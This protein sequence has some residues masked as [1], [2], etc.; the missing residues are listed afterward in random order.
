MTKKMI[1]RVTMLS[2]AIVALTLIAAGAGVFWQGGG[3]AYK[4][5]TL[6]G[7]TVMINGHGLYRYD[8]V[9][10]A[11]QAVAQDIVT[12]L[13]GIPFLL[14][15]LYYLRGDSLRG[16]LL[17][18]GITGYFLYTYM[19]YAVGANYNNMF[20]IY[21][22]VFSLSLSTLSMILSSIDLSTL[23]TH[24]S[25]KTPERSIAVYL[26][27]ISFLLFMAWMGRIV[28]AMIAGTAPAGLESNTT[29]FIQFMDLAIVI[30]LSVVAGILLIR[31]QPLGYLLSS[32][33]IIKTSTLAFSV[34]AMGLNMLLSGAS[35]SPAELIM[36]PA[37][38]VSG[39]V[40][41]V[42]MLRSITEPAK[43]TEPAEDSK[44]N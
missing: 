15:S 22:A 36:F 3:S 10:M 18:C 37:I 35:V 29:L 42:L 9:S 31:K 26:L 34:S 8:T 43:Q 30:P 12:L 40:L 41:M 23:K 17:F 6:R 16:K 33:M 25:E 38:A 28:P 5:T 11:A 4:F 13:I 2:L 39:I 20:L 32:I 19:S 7:E 24:F 1:S 21:V 27:G 44:N 14:I